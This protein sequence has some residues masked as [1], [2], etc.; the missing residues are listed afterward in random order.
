MGD[1]ISLARVV[2]AL[3]GESLP[4]RRIC[5]DIASELIKV[6]A[7]R[8]AA[9]SG[10][11]AAKLTDEERVALKKALD[12]IGSFEIGDAAPRQLS[13]IIHLLVDRLNSPPSR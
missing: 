2:L 5:S 8:D 6:S 11:I 1:P 7:E 10:S 4:W 12:A 3:N 13:R 9:R